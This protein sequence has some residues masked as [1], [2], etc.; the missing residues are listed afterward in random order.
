MNPSELVLRRSLPVF[1]NSF[2]QLHYLKDLLANLANFGFSNLW[3]LDNRSTYPSLLKFYE[4]LDTPPPGS[5]RVLYYPE[6]F[7]PRY[8]HLSGLYKT[9]WPYPHLYTDPDIA[10]E[11]IDDSFASTL[12]EISR[13]FKVAKV[14]SALTLPPEE[15]MTPVKR[16][17]PETGWEPVSVLD[18][19]RQFWANEIEDQ[20]YGVSIDTTLH[21][22]NPEFFNEENFLQGIRVGRAG[23]QVKH[24]PWFTN[25]LPP[26]EELEYYRNTRVGHG[27]WV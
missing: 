14:G 5:A 13:R 3:I 18:W 24:R 10:L 25:D 12:L 27:D 1:I 7:G 21:L 23:Y 8:F 9:V 26:E 20:V 4:T 11:T 19:E 6:N 15:L 22:F 17:F 2:N 16:G